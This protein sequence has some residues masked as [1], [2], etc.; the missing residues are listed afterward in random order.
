[1]EA[2]LPIGEIK[3]AQRQVDA[4]QRTV[5]KMEIYQTG[6]LAPEN[7]I[8]LNQGKI[9]STKKD[10]HGIGSSSSH[11]I[12]TDRNICNGR[13]RY[14]ALNDGQYPAQQPEKFYLAK[15]EIKV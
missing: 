14:R 11:T 13:I 2:S 3:I 4:L 6:F 7:V 15:I 8:L 10:G 9:F 5:L 12:I 1:M